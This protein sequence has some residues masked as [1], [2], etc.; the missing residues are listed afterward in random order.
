[1]G[2]LA[3]ALA[4]CQADVPHDVAGNGA[5]RDAPATTADP[6]PPPLPP[7]GLPAR[8]REQAAPAATLARYDGYGEL[9]FGMTEEIGR[10]HV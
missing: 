5:D 8:P 7:P 4:A 9:R 3:L 1:M 6:R 10:A 2:L